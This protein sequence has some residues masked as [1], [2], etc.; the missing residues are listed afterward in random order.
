MG[1]F[2][3]AFPDDSVIVAEHEYEGSWDGSGAAIAERDG[4]FL[5]AEY[6]HCSC[7]GPEDSMSQGI[8]ATLEEAIRSIGHHQDEIR[9]IANSVK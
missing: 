9:V 2:H 6:S 1:K 5:W 3:G 8:A 7:Y 4:V